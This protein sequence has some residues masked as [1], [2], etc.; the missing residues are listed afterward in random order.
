MTT[1]TMNILTKRMDSIL[2]EEPKVK[3]ER[4]I[5]FKKDLEG[6]IENEALNAEYQTLVR[7][8]VIEEMGHMVE[9]GEVA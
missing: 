8:R 4:L 1:G 5:I 2:K 6:M 9:T 3:W 7:N